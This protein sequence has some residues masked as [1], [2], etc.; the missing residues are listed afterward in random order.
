LYAALD[1]RPRAKG[2]PYIHEYT[3]W[4]T[5]GVSNAVVPGPLHFGVYRDPLERYLSAFAS[6]VMCCAN[7][8]A[9]GARRPCYAELIHSGQWTNLSYHLLSLN[10]A[11][12]GGPRARVPSPPCLFFDE[13]AASLHGIQLRQRQRSLNSHFA[14]QDLWCPTRS[15]ASRRGNG[16]FVL[17]TVEETLS[18][19]AGLEWLPHPHAI[20]LREVTS[21]RRPCI[22]RPW[23]IPRRGPLGRL[24]L[25]PWLPA[26]AARGHRERAAQ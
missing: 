26:V 25:C 18:A 22:K 24:E 23:F 9:D 17:G 21:V 13:F 20:S 6:K 14:P 8:T 12:L 5:P 1:G 19:L 3:L 16:T 10:G 7:R 11:A 4:G 15:A 2:R